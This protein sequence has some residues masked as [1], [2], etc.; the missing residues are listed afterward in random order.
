[1]TPRASG[2]PFGSLENL[3]FTG[4]QEESREDEPFTEQVVK[5]D[6]GIRTAIEDDGGEERVEVMKGC[7]DGFR[8][9]RLEHHPLASS[10]PDQRETGIVSGLD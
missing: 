2:G 8:T 4:I 10:S 7:R 1:M 6:H 9:L 3:S 5:S